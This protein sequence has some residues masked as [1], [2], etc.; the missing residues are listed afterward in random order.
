[1]TLFA[2]ER[3]RAARV[4]GATLPGLDSGV[5]E[6]FLDSFFGLAPW[7]PALGVRVLLGGLSVWPSGV[8]LLA[9]SRWYALREAA[10]LVKALA[11]LARGDVR[12]REG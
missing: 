4:L 10:V 11:T 2:R 12:G 5:A 6:A 1:M 9:R 7:L 8:R 3:R